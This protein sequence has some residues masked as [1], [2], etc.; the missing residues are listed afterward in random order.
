MFTEDFIVFFFNKWSILVRSES[1]CF[2]LA[3][4]FGRLKYNT[5]LPD[6]FYILK[7]QD[8]T[9][10]ERQANIKRPV[11][12]GGNSALTVWDEKRKIKTSK[13]DYYNFYQTFPFPYRISCFHHYSNTDARDNQAQGI[14]VTKNRRLYSDNSFLSF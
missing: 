1:S 2:M 6:S 10:S 8:S 7:K 13:K 14:T 11:Q 12:S 4:L 5:R 3:C 9:Q